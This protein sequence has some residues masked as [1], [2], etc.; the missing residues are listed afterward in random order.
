MKTPPWVRTAQGFRIFGW[1]LTPFIVFTL[2]DLVVQWIGD[3]ISTAPF[4][5][6][7]V[8]AI[9]VLRLCLQ[10]IRTTSGDHL[11]LW[12]EIHDVPDHERSVWEQ[13]EQR[14]RAK[15]M[16]HSDKNGARP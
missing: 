3:R 10:M 5:L 15:R 1:V 4:L 12:M 9:A 16:K 2:Q 8:L 7:F 6:I 11:T 13:Y 14:W